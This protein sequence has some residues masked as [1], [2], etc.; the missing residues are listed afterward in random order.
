MIFSNTPIERY[1][2]GKHEVWVK[3]EDL[4]VSAEGPTFSKVRGLE[5]YLKKIKKEGFST[6][7]YTE[8]SISMAGWG[9]SWLASKIGL[10]SV[11]FDPQYK[12]TPGILE[13]HRKQWIKYNP[14]IIPIKAGRAKVN[15]Y[16][17]RKI[18]KNKYGDKAILLPLG[19]PLKE[20]VEE[21][22]KEVKITREK[23]QLDF[24]TVVI[25][26]GSGTICAG[27]TRGF[28][29]KTIYGIMGRKGDVKRKIKFISQKG[30]FYTKGLL[31][32]NIKVIDMGWEYTER[33]KIKSPFPCHPY[34]DLKAWEWL[35]EN[36][37]KLKKPVLF[38]N[39]GSIP[40]IS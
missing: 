35:I 11:I 14:E 38:W 5:S 18:L 23:N 39:I 36:I 26:V 32:I 40:N 25:N 16:I 7:G 1:K 2:I 24:E 9:V 31:G 30:N 10:G 13:L 28:P 3:R 12:K 27:V 15:Y 21:T 6:V 29:D 37:S 34:Y 22:V 8:T 17:S 33:S 19:I 4:C 20:T